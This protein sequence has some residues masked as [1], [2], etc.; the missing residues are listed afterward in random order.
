ME[1]NWL[2]QISVE[3]FKTYH[4]WSAQVFRLSTLSQL[5]KS[6]DLVILMY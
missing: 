6:Q 2:A 4:Q 5:V 3:S 1:E